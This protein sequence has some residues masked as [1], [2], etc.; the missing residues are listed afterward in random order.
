M[1]R[2]LLTHANLPTD[3]WDSAFGT[4]VYLSN[5][6]PTPV[7]Q[8]R[9]PFVICLAVLLTI[10]SFGYLG[11]FVSRGFALIVLT[12]LILHLLSVYSLVTHL[13]KV[14]TV[15]I[16]CRGVV[17]IYL[18]MYV[19]RSLYSLAFTISL[20]LLFQLLKLARLASSLAAAVSHFLSTLSACL[21]ARLGSGI[22]Y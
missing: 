5:R 3:F 1:G 21:A 17:F 20:C 9:S 7:L 6:L 16:M 11:A 14:L 8:G 10:S 18:A 12:S 4:A 2:T 22:G 19:L 15:A 13:L